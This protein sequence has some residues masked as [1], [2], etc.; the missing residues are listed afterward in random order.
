[1][2]T[3]VHSVILTANPRVYGMNCMVVIHWQKCSDVVSLK[4]N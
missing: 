1:M 3:V 4:T 2:E